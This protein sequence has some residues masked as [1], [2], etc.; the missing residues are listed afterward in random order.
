MVSDKDVLKDLRDK[1]DPKKQVN[2]FSVNLEQQAP[3]V[4]KPGFE[5]FSMDTQDMAYTTLS[6]GEKVGMFES[7]VPGTDNMERLAQ[8]QSTGDKWLNG[9]QKFHTKV[10]NAVVGGTVGTVYGVG[11]WI[12]DG[13]LTALY[14]NDFSNYL[15]D[16]DTKMNYQLPNYYT[17]Q[18]TDKSLFGQAGTANFWADKVLGGLSFTVGAI[19]S[20]GIWA[21]ATGGS[22]LGLTAAKW[23][24]KA[25][26][27]TKVAKGLSTYKS[28]TK[29]AIKNAYKAGNIDKSL[30]IRMGQSL[31]V[32]NNVRFTLTSAGYESS[33]EALHYKRE[34]EEN[35]YENFEKLNGRPPE[36]ADIQAFQEDLTKGANAVFALNMAIVGSSNLVQFGKIFDIKSPFKTGF[37]EF[38][39][40]KAFGIGAEVTETAGK[41]ASKLITATRNQK[42]LKNLYY[43][44]KSPI[45]EGLWEEGMQGV[46]TNTLSQWVEAGYDPNA[47]QD[48]AELIG[49]TY[50]SLA[51]Q[52]GTREG[53]VENGVGMIIGAIGGTVGA[54][55][56]MKSAEEMAKY[57]ASGEATFTQK[58]IA[59]KFLM[60][61]RMNTFS[62]QAK[63]A[64]QKGEL[65]KSKLANDSTILA[66]MNYQHQIG[67]DVLDLVE[68]NRIAL[69]NTSVEEFKAAGVEE[70]NIEAYKKETL[71]QYE[72]VAR[73]FKQNRKYAEYTIGRNTMV[74]QKD[75]SVA[76]IEDLGLNSKEALV[77]AL[78]YTLTMGENSAALMKDMQENI[79]NEVGVEQ[80]SVFNLVSNLQTLSSEQKNLITAN[81]RKS[82]NL[83]KTKSKL[84]QELL[85]LQNAPKETEG[86]TKTGTKYAS[87]ANQILEIDSE[88]SALENELQGV[89]DLI[90]KSSKY[91]QGLGDL[92]MSP[93]S[94]IQEVT[95]EELTNLEEN[96]AKFEKLIEDLG[97]TNPQRRDYLKDVLAE[98]KTA[99]ETFLNYQNTA[100]ALSSGKVKIKESNNTFSKLINSK[101]SMDEFTKDWL[102]DIL[103][104]YQNLKL[105]S[106]RELE[107]EE[108][109]EEQVVS[110]TTG[111]ITPP[112]AQD[113]QAQ[114][115][116][117]EQQKRELEQLENTSIQINSLEDLD[118][119]T[120]QERAKLKSDAK[121][122]I[123]S[124]P[125]DLF[126]V[127]HLTPRAEDLQSII[128]NGLIIN[129]NL[130]GTSNIAADK[131]ALLNAIEAIIDGKV[132]HRG[133]AN[134]AIMG[135]PKSIV[136][137]KKQN[138][139]V[140]E[141]EDYLVENHPNNGLESVPAQYNVASFT[142]GKV[143]LLKGDNTTNQPIGANK[144]EINKINAKIE[145]LKKQ[146]PTQ[147]TV[148][149]LQAL[150]NRLERAL[151]GKYK[152]ITYEGEMVDDF[153]TKKPT[154]QEIEEYRQLK[155]EE[156][157]NQSRLGLLEQ[158]LGSWRLL[159]SLEIGEGETIAD[160]IDFISQLEQE[161]AEEETKTEITPQDTDLMHSTLE[162][163]ESITRYDFLQ[164]VHASVTVSKPKGKGV[165]VF[166]HLKM[167]TIIDRLGGE[168][169]MFK[170]KKVIENPTTDQILE[171]EVGTVFT[172]GGVDFKIGSGHNVEIKET[173]FTPSL[174][175]SLNMYIV[176][177]GSTNWTYKNLMQ[178]AGN[179]LVKVPSDLQQKDMQ[180][181]RIYNQKQ[182][183]KVRLRIQKT[184]WEIRLLKK[185][186][187]AK[188]ESAKKEIENKIKKSL[189]IYAVDSYGV[190]ISTLKAT[191][192]ASD[193][194]FLR[195]RQRAYDEFLKVADLD[196]K[197][198][199][200]IEVE[201]DG[202]FM[203]N[204]S[205]NIQDGVITDM[206]ITEKA[207]TQVIATGYILDGE[208]TTNKEV[209]DIDKTFTGKLSQ[210]NK[211]RKIPVVI[212]KKGAYNVA[213]PISVVKTADP[214]GSIIEDILAQKL[215]VVE[216]SKAINEAII[217]NGIA[218]DMRVTPE[219]LTDEVISQIIEQFEA[220]QT[221][222]T[223]DEFA[224][225]GYKAD[226]LTTDAQINIDLENIDQAI[227]D[228]K[229]R[230]KLD[231][232]VVFESPRDSKFVSLTEVEERMSDLAQEVYNDFV[233]NAD[234]KY[235]DSKGNIL[236]DTHY[237]D[238]F[239]ENPIE[240]P[241]SHLDKV[242]NANILEEAFSVKL[243]K[244]VEQ[245]LGQDLIKEV[246]DLIKTRAFVKTQTAPKASEVQNGENNICN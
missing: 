172:V 4:E 194:V 151:G 170:G 230:I 177:T 50:N 120:E 42:I 158:K 192:D 241:N 224:E 226:S 145:Q 129:G 109:T 38:M 46:T 215:D 49:M 198:D 79:A 13:S 76:G 45:T 196:Y 236:E 18:E 207:A 99:Q 178:V 216:T 121:A 161:I 103:E 113:I 140:Q 48:T 228:A 128:K 17:K 149:P 107:T 52:Y 225:Q 208:F 54:R 27:F 233:K 85:K 203:G 32:A 240:S 180:E 156:D 94:S 200:G 92:N 112:T 243:P 174:Q 199:I 68:Q 8:Q 136:E 62:Q 114:I 155:K 77:Q 127:I 40:R 39:N 16:L 23:G 205:L 137:G 95:V 162:D 217:V 51:H 65:V 234:T 119:L 20:E 169:K 73:Q 26:G 184:D 83:Q 218:T 193:E 117:L 201:V 102:T 106:A 147:P 123:D 14:D 148:T 9:I 74:G 229:L 213:Y 212:I 135:F 118:K 141:V 181:Q 235:V 81:T 44:G 25:L 97:T 125:D 22:S 75:V 116:A 202:I 11:K 19:V 133:S 186:K 21:A 15:A 153:L 139:Y 30:A 122:Q 5:S 195:I 239:D 157:P 66:Q 185:L 237:T 211:G 57:R 78:T 100:I 56:E 214:K 130:A 134:L 144:S 37:S 227:S 168:V 143:S 152:F 163:T 1:H 179:E 232:T 132:R 93:I 101:K 12:E 210:V 3:K 160:I 104:N 182:G 29:E 69:N 41:K 47:T 53:W 245:A 242:K 96:I 187:A 206:E 59:E 90:N 71:E 188:T 64:E 154:K 220:N 150:K 111:I 7:Y 138:Q 219:T 167:S 190:N 246:K 115:D 209:Q 159:D 70:S 142:N 6:S 204:P 24:T 189:V 126:F 231:D 110:D 108:I 60:M 165:L 10:A 164:N 86:N 222:R 43:Y 84:E 72:Q 36:D 176:D 238:T 183:G 55:S 31:D 2:L 197:Q 28:W 67:E 63:T 88:I 80:A 58:A 91:S 35:F 244:V 124:L 34:Q 173:T 191:R 87:V 131:T 171:A 166:H 98:Y 105:E 175:Q 221:Y 33:I 146:L 89:A 61:N 223:A 82:K